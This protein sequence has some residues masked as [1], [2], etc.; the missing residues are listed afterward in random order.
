MAF[1]ENLKKMRES[2]GITQADL[3]KQVYVSQPMIAQYEAE[4][5]VPSAPTALAIAKAL[6]TT[7]EKLMEG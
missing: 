6:G 7:F 5:R 2:K 1:A 4:I 3:A